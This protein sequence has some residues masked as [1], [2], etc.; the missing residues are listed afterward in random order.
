MKSV[1]AAA[2]AEE[3]FKFSCNLYCYLE[4]DE[5]SVSGRATSVRWFVAKVWPLVRLH[6]DP[7]AA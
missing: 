7:S 5:L 4:G 6:G 3:E 1:A 2:A